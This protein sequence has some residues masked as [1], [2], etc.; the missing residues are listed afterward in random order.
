MM[1]LN[2]LTL[3]ASFAPIALIVVPVL[4]VLFFLT[5]LVRQY[6]R[7]PSNRVLVVYG[8]SPASGRRSVCTVGGRLWSRCFRTTRTCRLSR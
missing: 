4:L 7:C 2:P 1:T 8:K 5:M 6:R 3:A